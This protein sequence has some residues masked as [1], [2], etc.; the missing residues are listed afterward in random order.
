MASS[1]SPLFFGFAGATL[2]GVE[3]S[4]CENRIKTCMRAV[5]TTKPTVENA[6]PFQDDSS[7]VHWRNFT[8][9]ATTRQAQDMTTCSQHKID[10][11]LGKY[12]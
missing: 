9:P 8:D 2:A 7:E 6:T 3:R 1:C 12:L 11:S 4:D 10:G 5:T